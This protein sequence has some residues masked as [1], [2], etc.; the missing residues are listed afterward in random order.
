[1]VQP[2]MGKPVFDMKSLHFG[3]N[4]SAQFRSNMQP[5]QLDP[6]QGNVVPNA[7]GPKGGVA[8]APQ[9]K[10]LYQPPPTNAS[11]AYPPHPI[12]TKAT[13][14]S[15]QISFADTKGAR[16]TALDKAP[17]QKLWIQSFNL[18]LLEQAVLGGATVMPI[19]LELIKPPYALK[20]IPML[21]RD[22]YRMDLL[23]DKLQIE[24]A[25]IFTALGLDIVNRPPTDQSFKMAWS[26]LQRMSGLLMKVVDRMKDMLEKNG[27]TCTPKYKPKT[28]AEVEQ[29]LF[30]A[31]VKHYL[32]VKVDPMPNYI[33]EAVQVLGEDYL[34]MELRQRWWLYR[35]SAYI[36]SPRLMEAPAIA[37]SVPWK[38]YQGSFDFNSRS[39]Y[40][41][42]D[43]FYMRTSMPENRIEYVETFKS[44]ASAMLQKGPAHPDF[45]YNWELVFLY[46]C[47]LWNSEVDQYSSYSPESMA[48]YSDLK[49]VEPQLPPRTTVDGTAQSTPT[50][51]AGNVAGTLENPQQTRS[52]V[53]EEVSMSSL[54]PARTTAVGGQG[55]KDDSDPGPVVDETGRN[56]PDQPVE[57]GSSDEELFGE[58]NPEPLEV[59]SVQTPLEKPTSTITSKIHVP[60]TPPLKAQFHSGTRR[61]SAFSKLSLPSAS[62]Q[63]PSIGPASSPALS[64][65]PDVNPPVSQNE[66]GLKSAPPQSKKRGAD[67]MQE[68]GAQLQQPAAQHRKRAKKEHPLQ[69][70]TPAVD[71]EEVQQQPQ[72]QPQPTESEASAIQPIDLTQDD[73][74][75]SHK[76]SKPRP[77]RRPD[78]IAEMGENGA[79]RYEYITTADGPNLGV[80][81]N[82]PEFIGTSKE[83]R[84]PPVNGLENALGI[85][86]KS[87]FWWT[88]NS[89]VLEEENKY[90]NMFPETKRRIAGQPS[91][92]VPKRKPSEPDW[93][94]KNLNVDHPNLKLS[95]EKANHTPL[96]NGKYECQHPCQHKDTCMHQCCKTTGGI[97]WGAKSKAIKD[98]RSSII[99]GWREERTVWGY[100]D[101]QVSY[102]NPLHEMQAMYQEEEGTIS[103]VGDSSSGALFWKPDSN[104]EVRSTILVS[105]MTACQ[106]NSV[107][108]KNGNFWEAVIRIIVKP[109]TD[110]P[111]ERTLDFIMASSASAHEDKNV[112]C[113][114][115]GG[116]IKAYKEAQDAEDPTPAASEHQAEDSE[117]AANG[118]IGDDDLHN[119]P[120]VQEDQLEDPTEDEE[121]DED[122]EGANENKW[123]SGELE[124]IY[125]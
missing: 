107:H 115:L 18:N 15:R 35:E 64:S 101:T 108:R 13:N 4:G 81:D 21:P 116:W 93:N 59:G 3:G 67:Q 24:G 10:L 60:A 94:G 123:L 22:L 82:N 96:A 112:F 48:A 77:N 17:E 92:D 124:I 104:K 50:Q 27:Q 95:L 85:G 117:E 119:L 34:D 65:T 44:C 86:R 7:N 14:P 52:A 58:E 99:R 88:R 100:K 54:D 87:K 31:P 33:A 8:A 47:K 12:G 37:T 122:D 39:P 53:W 111:T 20:R 69:D 97:N 56:S 114:L 6:V 61:D 80:F 43:L 32:D 84:P 72:P 23:T 62:S 41:I 74:P 30:P 49:V 78:P 1:M 76:Q 26:H 109:T 42:K 5:S 71:A 9:P 57:D 83:K 66:A 19:E 2:Q 105:D 46:S 103:L 68:D 120:E 113:E 75:E 79:E 89:A 45:A 29:A 55:S 102:D 36:K 110:E 25:H 106:K 16:P 91:P 118:S 51:Q 73:V 28:S 70:A 40:R 11:V 98:K 125:P 38:P 90:R 121:G 63:N